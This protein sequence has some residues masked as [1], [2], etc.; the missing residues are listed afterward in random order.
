[1]RYNLAKDPS[2]RSGTTHAFLPVQGSTLSVTSEYSFYGK[3][4]LSVIKSADNGSGVQIADPIPVVAGQPYAFSWYVRLPVTIPRAD[5]AELVLTVDW[6]NS[7]GTNIKSVT[8]ATL[9]IEDDSVWHRL[10]GVWTAPEG[11]T[12]ASVN[13]IR[14]LPG[15]AGSEIILDALLIEQADYIGG[16]FDNIPQAE[17]NRIV[18]KSLSAVPQVINGI[19][20]AADISLNDLIFNTID[21]DDTVWVVTDLEGWWG[22]TDPELPDIPRGTEDGSYDVEG[23]MTARTITLTGFFI[24]RN[25][26]GA[27]SAAIDRLVEAVSLVRKGGWLHA[28]E[29]P[30]KA[31]WV[32][33]A[34]RPEVRTV[35]PR[36]KTEFEITLR[37]G[38]PNKYHWNDSDPEGYSHVEFRS[39]DIQD[40]SYTNL[41]TNP[42]FEAGSTTRAVRVNYIQDIQFTTLPGTS[43]WIFSSSTTEVDEGVVTVTMTG[44]TT[45]NF[46]RPTVNLSSVGR[47]WAYASAAYLVENLSDVTRSFRVN[48]YDGVRLLNSHEPATPIPPGETVRVVGRASRQSDSTMLQPRLETTRLEA[49]DVIRV[50]QPILEEADAPGD[51]FLPGFESPD[52]DLT[53]VWPGAAFGSTPTLRGVVP[54]S[55]LP[56]ELELDGTS[57][58]IQSS[59]WASSGDYSLRIIPLQ[60]ECFVAIDAS[61]LTPG[62]SYTFAAT[63]RQ[64]TV[65]GG[66]PL[67]DARSISYVVGNTVVAWDQAPNV[68][69]ETDLRI[70][71]TAGDSGNRRFVLR[72]HAWDSEDSTGQYDTW[73]D[74]LLL[75]EGVYEGPYFDGN[76]PSRPPRIVHSWLGAENDSRSIRTEWIEDEVN[77]IGTATVAGLFTITGPVGAGTRIYNATTDETMTLQEPLR[78]AGMVANVDSVEATDGTATVYTT[79]AHGLRVGDRVSLLGMV[80]P[81]SESNLARV[82]THVSDVFPYSFSFDIPTDDIVKMSSE[83]QVVLLDND[84]L[85]VDT[86]NRSVTYNGEISGHRYRLTTL[87]D[88]IQFA[89]GRNLVEYYDNATRDEVIS[90]QISK[91]TVTLVTEDAHYLIPGEE[92]EVA[93]PEEKPL[94]RKSLTNN[95]ITL[96]TAEPHGFAVGDVVDV[97]STES[98]DI[99]TK[100]RTNNV[101][102]LTTEEPHGI[103]VSDSIRVSLPVTAAPRQKSLTSNVAR[104]TM[105][106]AHGFSEGDEVTVALPSSATIASKQLLNNQVI[107]TTTAPHNY[108]IGDTI[109]VTMP[110]GATVTGKARTGSQIIITTSTPHGFSVGDQVIISLPVTP[111]LKGTIRGDATTNLVTFD[112]NTPHGFS[113]GDRLSISGVMLMDVNGEKIVETV[114]TTTSFTVRDWN[115][116]SNAG[117]PASGVTIINLTNQS[118]NGTR[119]LV[120]ASG[121]TFGF[122]L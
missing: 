73:F 40:I 49:G 86:Y 71:F 68:V 120:T 3:Y 24:P 55:P 26:E 14:P 28:N 82:V 115:R 50:S 39:S 10:G 121:N 67:N 119:T 32:R 70:T 30:T 21:E 18:N 54:T 58:A 52:P 62:V 35:N 44:D 38:D 113:V 111:D 106:H 91:N 72:G 95:V 80:L 75:V 100:S 59:K 66:E 105:Q 15:I 102:T 17:K 96:T 8:S 90:K 7:L 81:F 94:L 33:L 9:V 79:A 22:Q 114:P 61:S 84:V 107:L 98:S 78:G 4:G 11:A 118:Y 53:P 37:A 42:S 41:F 122:N 69:G 74:S 97:E 89:P 36:G 65:Q 13:I 2:L 34:A 23:R 60:A 103:A 48:F 87:T 47:N 27:L 12:F 43:H 25:A 29:G 76:S 45:S 56:G 64:D 5:T 85:E 110:S 31:A 51:F 116:M 46:V 108:A 77:N 92:V 57:I 93:L 117:T 83:G 88:W 19:R 109:T 63:F 104:L 20:L 6:M 1:M 99:I 16:Y 101:A 112:T